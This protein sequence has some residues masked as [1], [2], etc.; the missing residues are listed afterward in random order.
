M[1]S[2]HGPMTYQGV[3]SLD[4]SALQLPGNPNNIVQTVRSWLALLLDSPLASTRPPRL[5]KAQAQRFCSGYQAEVIRLSRLSHLLNCSVVVDDLGTF[6]VSLH[7]EFKST[8]IFKEY[9][10]WYKTLD[11]SVYRYISSFLK[12]G[13]KS[14][15]FDP[16]F[17]PTAFRGWCETEN[18]L[19]GRRFPSHIV[20]DL[21]E[22]IRAS[23]LRIN[24]DD[25]LYRFGPGNVSES[26]IRGAPS[27]ARS[28]RFHERL[29]RVFVS[30]ESECG[31]HPHHHYL[32]PD[33]KLWEKGRRS[34]KMRSIEHGRYK[35]VVKDVTTERNIV[36]MPNSFQYFQQGLREALRRATQRTV[37]NTIIDLTSQER[38]R[39][40]ALLGS[41]TRKLS[42]TD[43]SKASD[44][45]H[46]DL[47]LSIFPDHIVELMEGCRVDKVLLPSGH[48]VRMNAYGSMGDAMCFD[49]QCIFFGAVSFLAAYLD[50]QGIPVREYLTWDVPVHTGDPYC[51]PHTCV[52]GD[53]LTNPVCQTEAVMSLLS[54]LGLNV[55]SSKSFTGGQGY[56][57]SC[58]IEALLGEDVT[59]VTNKVKGIRDNHPKFIQSAIDMANRLFEAGYYHCRQSWIDFLPQY[60]YLFTHP[61]SPYRRQSSLL[62]GYESNTHV[63]R[64]WITPEKSTKRNPCLYRMEYEVRI[65]RSRVKEVIT[66][67][68]DMYQLRQHLQR[69]AVEK[70]KLPNNPGRKPPSGDTGRPVLHSV[71]M[72]V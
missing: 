62:L 42:T 50:R 13:K 5:I 56:R 71:W 54:A 63:R 48:V 41:K 67:Q 14:E 52:Y 46:G 2:P 16:K 40:A 23:G 35:T 32:L 37:F 53:D 27:K 26:S 19:E 59:P 6:V 38:N 11:P 8:P 7:R 4:L 34:V 43:L 66:D 12:Y 68:Y 47:I 1:K 22:I 20:D 45:L 18:Q 44:T 24:Y 49:V 64:R 65:L 51:D 25:L 28:I 55:N 58:G 15:Y 17:Q 57:E 70:G 60:T 33:V 69:P 61:E 3:K 36:M 30:R 39:E 21:R 9:E 31:S 10:L 72:A 29:D